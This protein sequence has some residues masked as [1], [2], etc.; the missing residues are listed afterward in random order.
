MIFI[1]QVFV[2]HFYFFEASNIF[3]TIILRYIRYGTV[4]VSR[5]VCQRLEPS[6]VPDSV[7][8]DT[9]V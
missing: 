3:S 8:M 9:K 1:I 4:V 5:L 6:V 7:E 2:L